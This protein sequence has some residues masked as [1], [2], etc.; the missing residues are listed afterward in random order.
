MTIII[1]IRITTTTTIIK[2]TTVATIVVIIS[3]IAIIWL[4]SLPVLTNISLCSSLLNRL[5]PDLC[6]RNSL[7]EGI[8]IRFKKTGLIPYPQSFDI[9]TTMEQRH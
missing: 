7:Y 5:C 9:T 8:Y 4:F 6:V 3:I 2:T 1:I